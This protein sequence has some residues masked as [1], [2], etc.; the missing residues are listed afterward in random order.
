MDALSILQALLSTLFRLAAFVLLRIIPS[1]LA[2]RAL[3]ALGLAYLS[4]L[5]IGARHTP[6]EDIIPLGSLV[7]SLPTNSAALRRANILINVALALMVVEFVGTP[8]LDPAFD[9]TFSR[10]GA[11]T[12]DSVKVTV[13]S[14]STNDTGLVLW[15]EKME[16]EPFNSW[17]NGPGLVFTSEADWVTTVRLSGLWPNTSYEYAV[18]DENRTIT[19]GPF[20][21]RTFPDSRLTT[22]SHFRFVASSCLTPNFPYVPFHGRSIKGFDLLAQYLYPVV[23]PEDPLPPAEFM[24]LLGDFVYSDIPTYVGDNKEA[25]RRLY[26]RNYQSHSFKAIYERLPI[27]HTYDDHEIK[28]N[29]IGQA[30]ETVEAQDPFINASDAYTLYNSAA[31]YDPAQAGQHYY[32][33]RYADAAFFVL[34]TRR[35]RVLAAGEDETAGTMLGET[36]L[37][38]LHSWLSHANGTASFKFIVSSVPFTSLWGLDGQIDTW[39]GFPQ[40]KASLL[41]ALH[42]VPN[43]IIISGDRHEFASI[44]FNGEEDSM[45]TVREYST[46][47]L[48]MFDVPFVRTLGMQSQETYP[49]VVT[50]EDGNSTIEEVPKERVVKYLARGNHKWSSFELDSRDLAKPTL[51]IELVIDG[52]IRYR[53]ELVGSPVK[54]QSSNALGAFVTTGIKDVF[55]RIGINPS[56]WF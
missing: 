39:A 5:C 53:E 16:S 20:V 50:S 34:D 48:S 38:A 10:I 11:V 29:F 3:V 36:Q 35:Y 44:E 18:A 22:G 52:K 24:L 1:P 17:R 13:R 21:F 47:P 12:S 28:N 23:Q 25:Y 9:V 6:T 31:N 4:I 15:R 41:A 7:L 32:S 45:H 19:S 46:S 51:R 56:R 37:A 42:T 54:L 2:L 30:N 43:V 26:R 14:P 27:L 55:N 49:R 40:E 33:F 8:Y